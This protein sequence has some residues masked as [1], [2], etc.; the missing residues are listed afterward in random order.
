MGGKKGWYDLLQK[1]YFG[2]SSNSQE[3]SRNF[4]LSALKSVKVTLEDAPI[5]SGDEISLISQS[6]PGA[7]IIDEDNK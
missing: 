2:T 4:N 6:F 5:E 1:G 7:Q 3:S